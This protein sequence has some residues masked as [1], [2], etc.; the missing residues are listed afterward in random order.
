MIS[1][2]SGDYSNIHQA[3]ERWEYEL[4]LTTVH[5]SKHHYGGEKGIP[6]LVVA[7]PEKTSP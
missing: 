4:N 6:Y 5:G 2:K 3:A 1:I 7:L